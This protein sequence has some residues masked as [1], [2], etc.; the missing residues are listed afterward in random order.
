MKTR[1]LGGLLASIAT[2]WLPEG[3]QQGG[4]GTDGAPISALYNLAGQR[5]S[6]TRQ[7]AP[8]CYVV[9]TPSGSARTVYYR[10]R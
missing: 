4:N 6:P 8:G 3:E 1:C 9:K 7:P 2:P 5:L 10:A